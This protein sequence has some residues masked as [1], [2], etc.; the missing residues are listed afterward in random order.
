MGRGHAVRWAPSK[1]HLAVA[2]QCLPAL[3]VGPVGTTVAADRGAR[4]GDRRALSGRLHRW[5]PGPRGC[6]WVPERLAGAAGAVWPQP[7]PGQDAPAG[8]W[9]ASRAELAGAWAREAGDLPVLG[10]R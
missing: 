5:V 8:V 9:A 4:R 2:R 1:E 10:V 3:R 7:P 6:R